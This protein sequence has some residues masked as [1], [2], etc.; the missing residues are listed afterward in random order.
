[1][2]FIAKDAVTTP[3]GPII[4]GE[5][6]PGGNG[7]GIVTDHKPQ[8]AKGTIKVDLN[9]VRTGVDRRDAQMRSAS[10]LDT[11]KGDVNRYAVFEI[12]H[13]ELA[14]PLAPGKE[15]PAKIRGTFTVRGKPI[16]TL[17]DGTITYIKLPPEQLES[18][19]RFGFTADNLRVKTRLVTRFT[20][21]GM[22][23]PE[24]LILK[25]SDD[26]QVETDLI[27]VKSQ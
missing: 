26:I 16:E 10:F 7:S 8:D 25:L 21:H 24:L 22:Q 20:N 3:R 5:R 1:M 18:Q 19:K 12:K 17:A 4:P 23:V 2:C 14:G 6:P 11:E 27:L 15:V 9:A 13:V